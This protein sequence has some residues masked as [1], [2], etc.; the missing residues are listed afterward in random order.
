MHVMC[1]VKQYAVHVLMSFMQNAF[2]HLRL[3][4]GVNYSAQN[5]ALTGKC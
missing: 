4:N 1:S 3:T 2:V 5:W